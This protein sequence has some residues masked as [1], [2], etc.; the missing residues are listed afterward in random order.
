MPNI[1]S[2]IKHHKRK[3]ISHDQSISRISFNCRDKSSCSRNDNC[4]QQNVVYYSKV[5]STDEVTNK[6]YPHYI[7]LKK[8]SFK[9]RLYKLKSSFKY[10]NNGNATKLSNFICNQKNKS[11]DVT[12]E[13]SIPGKTKPYSPG[14]WNCVL[15]LT[16]NN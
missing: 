11:I 13:W 7:E 4:L 3:I 2:I 12:L 15:C 8:S 9:D 14:S 10:E 1:S 6:N 16:K 5:I